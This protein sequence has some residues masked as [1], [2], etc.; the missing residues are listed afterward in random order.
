MKK[1]DIRRPGKIGVANINQD[2]VKKNLQE[3]EKVKLRIGVFFDGTGNNKFNSDSV[4][5][6]ESVYHNKKID[7]PPLIESQIPP[8]N[9][10]SFVIESGSSYWNS[11]SNIALL[12]DIYEQKIERNKNSNAEYHSL[13]LK[14]YVEGI[15]TLQT[16]ED[17]K[18]GSGFGEGARGVIARVEQTCER[19]ANDVAIA[20]INIQDKKKMEII[21]IKFDVFGFSRGAAA[22]R[23]F[24]NEVLK[25]GVEQI[26]NDESVFSSR[27]KVPNINK[28]KKTKKSLPNIQ[29]SDPA[30]YKKVIDN[31]AVVRS[32]VTPARGIF[33]GGVLGKFLKKHKIT[34]PKN[35]V[36][37]EF[38]G[39]FDTVISQMLERKGIIDKARNPIDTALAVALSP[40]PL[41]KLLTTI[42]SVYVSLIHKVNPRLNNPHIRKI[43]HIMA[44]TEWR[45]NFPVTPIGI[46]S[47]I[48]G[49][50]DYKQITALGSHSDIGGG[51]WHTKEEKDTV[52]HFFD[53]S[54]DASDVEKQELEKQK[55]LLRKWY[56]SKKFFKEDS[57]INWKTSHHLHASKLYGGPINDEKME[58]KEDTFMGDALQRIVDGWLYTV[59]GY[60]YKLTTARPIN[61]KLALV[62]MNVMKDIAISHGGVPFLDPKKTDSDHRPTHPEEYN[63]PDDLTSYYKRITQVAE[64]GWKDKDGKIT[65]YP[66]LIDKDGNYTIPETMYNN[67]MSNYVHLSANFTTPFDSSIDHYNFAYANVPHF[68]NEKEFKNP[69]YERQEY[70]PELAP[71]D[72]H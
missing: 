50:T 7:R 59:K 3:T 30:N 20:L 24:C 33:T 29:K 58:L 68:T 37:I 44:Q 15:G 71:Y 53:I 51:Y 39:I 18:L 45:D 9:R 10:K 70:T 35:N 16:E 13:Q 23:H 40:T 36:S 57:Q 19:I 47:D 64:H 60:H 69:P 22:A 65:T 17:D 5:Y 54:I 14:F 21:S 52:L 2:E 56:I 6:N 42:A 31:T 26:F 1:I 63:L 4:Y 11:Y 61:N 27:N 32:F 28:S 38:L 55:D 48:E 49:T 34:F 41:S 43:F 67:V 25:T 8:I 66:S 72:T 12:Y 62:Y 46:I